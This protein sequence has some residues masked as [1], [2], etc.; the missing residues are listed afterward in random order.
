MN[1]WKQSIL[2]IQIF[3]LLKSWLEYFSCKY[4]ISKDNPFIFGIHLFPLFSQALKSKLFILFWHKWFSMK[5]PFCYHHY[6]IQTFHYIRELFKMN[7]F[8]IP[9]FFSCEYFI[10]ENKIFVIIIIT[11]DLSFKEMHVWFKRYP[12]K[13]CLSKSV[14]D[15]FHFWFKKWS[16]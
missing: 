2:G 9:W 4:F 3:Q 7:F 8:S 1:F 12:L 15:I 6:G 11:S 13:L 10:F 16:F 5:Q 14:K